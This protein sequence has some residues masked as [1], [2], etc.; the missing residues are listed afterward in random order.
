MADWC[1]R[2]RQLGHRPAEGGPRAERGSWGDASPS[3]GCSPRHHREKQKRQDKG[4]LEPWRE[5]SSLHLDLHL[6]AQAA[7]GWPPVARCLVLVAL[8]WFLLRG[9][10]Q[11]GR[12][13]RPALPRLL[14]APG[15]RGQRGQ[16]LVGSTGSAGDKTGRE[17]GSGSGAASGGIPPRVPSQGWAFGLGGEGP[18]PPSGLDPK[19]APLACGSRPL[20]ISCLPPSFAKCS[21]HVS[22]LGGSSLPRPW[23]V[24]ES[25]SCRL[26]LSTLGFECSRLEP[27]QPPTALLLGVWLSPGRDAVGTQHPPLL[28][29]LAPCCS[30]D[31]VRG[32]CL[33]APGSWG[34]G[35][36][37]RLTW[38][39]Q[40]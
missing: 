18:G 40:V 32:P 24:S 26:A 5:P 25:Q 33:L 13:P 11:W 19:F 3:R 6:G 1:V 21:K 29:G 23:S 4:S 16:D 36:G 2:R 17:T 9:G 15:R 28:A 39:R 8:G 20:R 31:T 38:S 7:R 14:R 27:P 22:R 12:P 37:G 10:Q 34:Q 30:P 35:R